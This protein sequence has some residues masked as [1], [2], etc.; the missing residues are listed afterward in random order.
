[1]EHCATSER[2]TSE[3]LKIFISQPE[4]F[5]FYQPLMKTFHIDIVYHCYTQSAIK[6]MYMTHCWY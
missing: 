4:T 3:L 2:A 6:H 1:M 5:T